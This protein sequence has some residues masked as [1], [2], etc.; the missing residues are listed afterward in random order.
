MLTCL[1]T[2]PQLVGALPRP[3]SHE[4][5]HLISIDSEGNG[6]DSRDSHR[7]VTAT[8]G[9]RGGSAPATISQGTPDGGHEGHAHGDYDDEHDHHDEDEE[10]GRFVS[11]LVF[12]WVGAIFLAGT[13]FMCGYIVHEL[14]P[15]GAL[16]T[17]MM[18]SLRS[19]EEGLKDF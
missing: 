15:I 16:R 12:L 1:P 4:K 8:A 3:T 5:D 17:R 11:G 10:G 7:S 6:S 18:S 13:A 9:A 2:Y 14:E 19:K